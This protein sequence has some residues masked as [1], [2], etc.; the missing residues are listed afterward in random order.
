VKFNPEDE[1]AMDIPLLIRVFEYMREEAKSDIDV[2]DVAER[3]ISLSSMGRVLTMDDYNKIVP[4]RDSEVERIKELS[5]AG[6]Y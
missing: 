2:H 5:G 6:K 4:K 1:V 3:L